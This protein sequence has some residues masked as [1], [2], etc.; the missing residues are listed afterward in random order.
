MKLVRIVRDNGA[1][2]SSLLGASRKGGKNYQLKSLNNEKAFKRFYEIQHFAIN[3]SAFELRN[4][5][6]S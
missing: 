5:T 4:T 2:S 6:V 1:A 3:Y